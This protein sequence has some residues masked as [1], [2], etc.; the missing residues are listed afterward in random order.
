MYLQQKAKSGI[1]C[2]PLLFEI[3]A[4][5]TSCHCKQRVA[6]EVARNCGEHPENASGRSA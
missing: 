5:F 3:R 2:G 1:K 4:M 6:A